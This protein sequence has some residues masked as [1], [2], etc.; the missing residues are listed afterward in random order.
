MREPPYTDEQIAR[1]AR[2]LVDAMYAA[3]E[4]LKPGLQIVIHPHECPC[5]RFGKRYAPCNCGGYE[6][7]VRIADTWDVLV[8]MLTEVNA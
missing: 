4:T 6:R 1:A 2:D 8:N 5:W 3:P 7:G